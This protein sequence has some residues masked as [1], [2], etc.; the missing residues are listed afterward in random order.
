M[1]RLIALL[2][3]PFALL[4]LGAAAALGAP[5]TLKVV[6]ETPTLGRAITVAAPGGGSFRADP[7]HARAVVTPQGGTSFITSVWCVDALRGVLAGYEYDVDLQTAADA[8]ILAGWNEAAWLMGQGDA[9]LAAAADPDME[10][11]AIQVAIWQLTG[12][13]AD[14]HDVTGNAAL[15]A[16]VAELRALAAGKAPVTALALSA[17]SGTL[18]AGGTGTVTVTGTPGAQVALRVVSGPATLTRT[19]VTLDASGSAQVGVSATGSGRIVVGAT[20]PGGILWRAAHLPDQQAPQDQAYLL[21]TELTAEATLTAS[22]AVVPPTVT[23]V[24]RAVLGISKAAPRRATVG[25]RITYSIRVVNRSAVTARGVVVRDNL[26]SGLVAV[27]VPSGASIR[28]GVVTWRVGDMAPRRTVTLRVTLRTLKS[29]RSTITN[30]ATASASNASR[31]SA[32]AVTR[33]T[34]LPS[35]VQP[36]VTG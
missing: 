15:N 20:A 12:N 11:A 3:V 34:P 23:P 27:R 32:R 36:A 8:P 14:I 13:A 16:R 19:Q 6:D 33:I 2:C 35:A 31:V 1:R 22:P 17:G 30:T 10:A 7:G 29:V 21:P 26:P 9:L 4:V 5:G 28:N 25:T 24:S 18:T